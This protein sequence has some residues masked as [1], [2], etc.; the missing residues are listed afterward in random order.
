MTSQV[1][2]SVCVGSDVVPQFGTQYAKRKYDRLCC[3]VVKNQCMLQELN[4]KVSVRE[5]SKLKGAWRIIMHWRMGNHRSFLERKLEALNRELLTIRRQIK[6]EIKVDVQGVIE[7]DGKEV[8]RLVQRLIFFKAFFKHPSCEDDASIDKV[9]HSV[10]EQLRQK[11]SLLVSGNDEFTSEEFRQLRKAQVVFSRFVDAMSSANGGGAFFRLH[12]YVEGA[13]FEISDI[14]NRCVL[15]AVKTGKQEFLADHQQILYIL[16]QQGGD[17]FAQ[18]LRNGGDLFLCGEQGKN[19]LDIACNSPESFTI[20]CEYLE[21]GAID[22]LN[23]DQFK[24]WLAQWIVDFLKNIFSDHDDY[25]RANRLLEIAHNMRIVFLENDI[26]V[27]WDWVRRS[28]FTMYD[29]CPIFFKLMLDLSPGL[30][31]MKT[32]SGCLIHKSICENKLQHLELILAKNKAC[33]LV[34]DNE[35]G[36]WGENALNF[37]VCFGNTETMSCLLRYCDM[38]SKIV[39]EVFELAV[40]CG[41]LDVAL[42]FLD[43]NLPIDI[44][45]PVFIDLMR[46]VAVSGGDIEEVASKVS[47]ER[48]EG[49]KARILAMCDGL[50]APRVEEGGREYCMRQE[51]WFEFFGGEKTQDQYNEEFRRIVNITAQRLDTDYF[52]VAGGG[53]DLPKILDTIATSRSRIAFLLDHDSASLFGVRRNHVLGTDMRGKYERYYELFEKNKTQFE[54]DDCWDTVDKVIGQIVGYTSSE[55]SPRTA[56]ELTRFMNLFGALHWIHTIPDNIEEAVNHANV[57]FDKIMEIPKPTNKAEATTLIN[58]IGELHWWLAHA[59][60]FCRGSASISEMLVRALFVR[61]VFR[62]SR[63]KVNTAPDCIALITP[64]VEEFV[65]KYKYLFDPHLGIN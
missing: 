3:L 28:A 31:H 53:Y 57:L 56:I 17:S 4:A 1:F 46:S 65:R 20:L 6:Y 36:K 55:H 2:S 8:E 49:T 51:D 16:A 29:D 15:S 39:R 64:D 24:Q 32:F 40:S 14:I 35:Y 38:N 60:P 50:H 19:V 10:M 63:L 34:K 23:R 48:S 22:H 5:Q 62:M 58:K 27:N 26:P 41:S 59:C 13:F 30:L 33:I 21:S 52:K 11:I 61:F 47:K 25:Q 43:S 42:A 37:A 18:A 7:N 54:G 44:E 12:S 45:D 9:V